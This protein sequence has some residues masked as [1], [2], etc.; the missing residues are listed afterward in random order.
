[1][2]AARA[3][4]MAAGEAIEAGQYE[5]TAIAR[6]T[7]KQARKTIERA[8]VHLEEAEKLAGMTEAGPV[9]PE[10]PLANPVSSPGKWPLTS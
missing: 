7:I 1:M 6:P 8:L 9:A 10:A 3:L 4:A 5:W 2:V